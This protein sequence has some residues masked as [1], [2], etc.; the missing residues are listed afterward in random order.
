MTGLGEFDVDD[1]FSET[2]NIN[3]HPL[4]DRMRPEKIDEF[5]GQ[6]HLLAKEKPLYK[7]ISNNRLHS[8]IFWGP[9]G[10]G[11]TTLARLISK[12][13]KA[14][15]IKLS[16]VMAGVKEIRD[17]V[18]QAQQFQ[19]NGSKTIVFVDEAHRFNK[20]QQDGFLPFIE[21]GTFVFIGATTE[22]PSF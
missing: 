13:V 16:A 2:D 1:M 17:A 21:D 9:P 18:A 11:K 3:D 19:A 7:L 22:N 10:T 12:N 4:A 20:V 6:D 5:Y 15:F 14:R 8:M